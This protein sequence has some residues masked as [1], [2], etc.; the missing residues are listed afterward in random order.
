M[1]FERA[2]N[3]AQSWHETLELHLY[4]GGKKLD[5]WFVP[6]T[7]MGFEFV[8]L[9]T[10]DEIVREA[11]MMRN[12]VRGYGAPLASNSQR[13]WSIR[14]EGER[15]ATLSIDRCDRL[16]CISQL[17]GPANEKAP[18]E[19][20]AAAWRWMIQH[21]PFGFREDRTRASYDR[22]TWVA[23]WRHYWLAKRRLPGWLPL[24]PSFP[25][26]RQLRHPVSR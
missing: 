8:P 5:P 3:E 13:L 23:L 17:Q 19:I 11:K 26:M 20:W 6:A 22:K 16:P 25:A 10:A 21:D 9:L 2:L 12:C 4:L 18:Q 1:S 7:I 14:N 24:A 15:V